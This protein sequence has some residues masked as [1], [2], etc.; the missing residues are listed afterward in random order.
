MSVNYMTTFLNSISP[1][2][3]TKLNVS[4]NDVN[5]LLSCEEIAYNIERRLK[6]KFRHM[7]LDDIKC[8]ICIIIVEPTHNL[9]HITVPT[10]PVDRFFAIWTMIDILR[11]NAS[12]HTKKILNK[13]TNNRSLETYIQYTNMNTVKFNVNRERLNKL[14]STGWKQFDDK[15]DQFITVGQQQKTDKMICKYIQTG[16]LTYDDVVF[17][18]S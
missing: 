3:S 7:N 15:V 17:Y 6:N 9:N 5:T 10:L 4:I 13:F 11:T 14:T 8:M 18:A 16:V 12:T 2:V 1:E